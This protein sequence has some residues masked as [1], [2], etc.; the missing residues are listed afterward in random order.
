MLQLLDYLN[1]VAAIA[2][3]C[4]YF[5]NLF[6]LYGSRCI[7]SIFNNVHDSYHNIIDSACKKMSDK[8]SYDKVY[9]L[10]FYLSG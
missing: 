6:A 3:L 4:E 1:K 9:M 7:V 8:K 10:L 2:S 5:A